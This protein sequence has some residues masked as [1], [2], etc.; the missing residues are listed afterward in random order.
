MTKKT[1][2]SHYYLHIRLICH[3]FVSVKRYKDMKTENFR[4]A[5]DEIRNNGGNRQTMYVK[6]VWKNREMT[7]FTYSDGT[8]EVFESTRPFMSFST[9]AEAITVI[10]KMQLDY[11]KALE[12]SKARA[13]ANRGKVKIDYCSLSDYYGRCNVYYGD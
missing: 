2:K 3:I 10:N 5:V 1:K 8:S 11:D 13:E 6:E 12:E 9:E 4:M 7:I